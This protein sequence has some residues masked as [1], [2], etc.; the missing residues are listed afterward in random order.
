MKDHKE[1][2]N[3][4]LNSA[5]PYTGGI[6]GGYQDSDN[7]KQSTFIGP[8]VDKKIKEVVNPLTAGVKQAY[9]EYRKGT[10][11]TL[12]KTAA[13]YDKGGLPAAAGQYVRGTI[14]DAGNALKQLVGKPVMAGVVK[15]A[16]NA[17]RGA[18]NFTKT[19]VTGNPAPIG[20]GKQPKA[21]DPLAGNLPTYAMQATGGI[22]NPMPGGTLGHLDKK[23]MWSGKELVSPSNQTAPAHKGIMAGGVRYEGQN[24]GSTV[25]TMGTPGQDGYGKVTLTGNLPKPGSTMP[26]N[27]ASGGPNASPTSVNRLAQLGDTMGTTR[28]GAS[29]LEFHGKASDAAKFFGTQY[30]DYS[31]EEKAREYQKANPYDTQN[32]YDDRFSYKPPP[33]NQMAMIAPPPMATGSGGWKSQIAADK[34]NAAAYGDYTR[35]VASLA[36]NQNSANADRYRTDMSYLSGQ[37]QNDLARKRLGLDAALNDMNL[38]QGEF[39]LQQAKHLNDLMKQAAAE[40]HQEKKRAL[41]NEI[42]MIRH[43]SPVKPVF[44]TVREDDGVGGQRERIFRVNDDGTMKEVLP[45][46]SQV[47]I[48]RQKFLLQGMDKK[49]RKAHLDDLARNNPA[50]FDALRAAYQQRNK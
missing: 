36:A 39:G 45:T 27:G 25:Y 50:L 11:D 30:T 22:D 4:A 34:A 10:Q 48:T 7:N 2:H 32:P 5:Y 46:I 31:N 44:Q 20:G 16:L 8:K 18:A 15:P 26:N 35:A 41:L 29:G 23:I 19:L 9:G 40:K 14:G 49:E 6:Y 24:D 42:A 28:E 38:Q 17:S 47:D 33:V 21:I 3:M 43:D 1:E 37:Q 13:A 12:D